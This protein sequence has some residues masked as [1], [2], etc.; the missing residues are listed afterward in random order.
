MFR[1]PYNWRE[2]D[3]LRR[4]MNRLFESSL[5]NVQRRRAPTFPAINVW[6]NDREGVVVTAE[7][8]GVNPDDIDISVTADTMTLSGERRAEEMAESAKYHRQERTYGK[9]SRTFQLPFTVDR[10]KVEAAVN[11]GVLQISLPRAAAEKP[12]QIAVQTG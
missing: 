2:V 1:Q 6:T 3:R 8:P 4:D 7:L 11:N 10:D 12:K 5:P 9:F